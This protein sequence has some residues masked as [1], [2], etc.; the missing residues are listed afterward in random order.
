MCVLVLFYHGSNA[1]GPNKSEMDRVCHL[2]FGWAYLNQIVKP[3]KRVQIDNARFVQLSQQPHPMHAMGSPSALAGEAGTS[4]RHLPIL[5]SSRDGIRA[6]KLWQGR[7]V[8]K[9]D[10]PVKGL[11]AAWVT[12]IVSIPS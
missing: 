7:A 12:V 9:N 5:E 6:W 2:I 11:A 3:S 8:N 4:R 10:G 1:P